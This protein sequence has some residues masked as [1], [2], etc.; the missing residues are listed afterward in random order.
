MVG[1]RHRTEKPGTDWRRFALAGT[2]GLVLAGGTV[3]A[4]TA[5]AAVPVYFAVSGST[6]TVTA[7][8]LRGRNAVQYAS[9]TSGTDKKHPVAVAS[10]ADATLT[11]LCQSSVTRTPLGAV[12][13]TIRTGENR[14]VHARDLVIDLQRLDGDL[15][16]KDVRMGQDA[17]TLRGAGPRARPGAYGQ[18]ARRLDINDV[19]VRAW[20]VAAATFELA[21]AS[22]SIRPGAHPCA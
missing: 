22:M 20:S 2:A 7:D 21:D 16:F 14:S 18:Q 5:T 15:H 12:T 10:I 3:A 4:T 17:S 11:N 1:G 8:T 13:L 6:F 9:V 19:K